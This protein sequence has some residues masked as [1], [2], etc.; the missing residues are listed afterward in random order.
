MIVAVVQLFSL[1]DLCACQQTK[2]L[3]QQENEHCPSVKCN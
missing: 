3:R 2:G 1:M